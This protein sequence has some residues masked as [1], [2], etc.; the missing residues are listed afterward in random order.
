MIRTTYNLFDMNFVFFRLVHVPSANME[1]AEPDT[2]CVS[3]VHFFFWNVHIIWIKSRKLFQMYV[4]VQTGVWRLS[5][6]V[7]VAGNREF[8]QRLTVRGHLRGKLPHARDAL[9]QS[10]PVSPTLFQLNTATHI[11]YSQKHTET[12][13]EEIAWP[14]VTSM[15]R[16]CRHYSL[17]ADV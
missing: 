1:E 14:W 5:V 16:N 3:V 11:Q 2:R 8:P 4:N 7:P 6:I 9:L 17:E 10:S 15:E 12:L 13:I